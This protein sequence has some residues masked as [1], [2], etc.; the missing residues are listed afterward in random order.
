MNMRAALWSAAA[1]CRTPKRL[2]RTE[3]YRL[4]RHSK[5]RLPVS[6]NPLQQLNSLG[7]SVWFDYIRRIE[8]TSGHMKQLIDQ[9][10]VSGITSNPSI[11][12]KA[13]AGGDD[14]DEDIRKLVGEGKDAPTIFES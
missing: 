10:G 5:R 9:D 11:F 13:I 7:Q 2:R 3:V 4:G 6:N 14:Y 1:S 8:L 12:E